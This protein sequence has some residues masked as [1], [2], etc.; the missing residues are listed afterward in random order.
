MECV[1]GWGVGGAGTG[2]PNAASERVSI[3]FLK[4]NHLLGDFL[5]QNWWTS[6][7]S[8]LVMGHLKNS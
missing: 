4:L 1:W 6:F 2:F 3:C 8:V 7:D 5:I